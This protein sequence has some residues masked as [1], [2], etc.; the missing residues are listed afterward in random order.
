V[1]GW[2]ADFLPAVEEALERVGESRSLTAADLD[3]VKGA[4][5]DSFFT[6]D[7]MSQVLREDSL[8]VYASDLL[9]PA[10]VFTWLRSES[11]LARFLFDRGT[12]QAAK[13]ALRRRGYLQ[14][15][16]EG[17]IMPCLQ[18]LNGVVNDPQPWPA[19]M[20]AQVPIEPETANAGLVAGSG[21]WERRRYRRML[22][23]D[24]FEGA[25]APRLGY[26][27]RLG[28]LR[29][30]VENR[31]VGSRLRDE[32]DK[33]IRQRMRG[34]VAV[35]V[36]R[37]EYPL[38]NDDQIVSFP[39]FVRALAD[40]V[41]LAGRQWMEAIARVDTGV[42]E[43]CRMIR[44]GVG[45]IVL[46][47]SELVRCLNAAIADGQVIPAA[48]ATAA[49]GASAELRTFIA[50]APRV[51]RLVDRGLALF[52]RR[53]LE[54]AFR[55]WIPEP[56]PVRWD[57][58]TDGEED[59]LDGEVPHLLQDAYLRAVLDLVLVTRIPPDRM[60]RA[61]RTG[62][63]WYGAVDGKATP[64]VMDE[65]VRWFQVEHHEAVVAW[66]TLGDE[67][68]KDER[69]R[70]TQAKAVADGEKLLERVGDST[71]REVIGR[72]DGKAAKKTAGLGGTRLQE[73]LL[74][75]ARS[76][77]IGHMDEVL[78]DLRRV[79]GGRGAADACGVVEYARATVRLARAEARMVVHAG[80]RKAFETHRG[81]WVR[82]QADVGRYLGRDQSTIQ[83]ALRKKGPEGT[84]LGLAAGF[85]E[86]R[87]QGHTFE[88]EDA[89]PVGP[90][91]GA[92]G[93]AKK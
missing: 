45:G 10:N 49:A 21:M 69:D 12:A 40:P 81:R 93:K 43:K 60:G 92:P 70:E 44:D 5:M 84:L 24:L 72:L 68:G 57:E 31:L 88:N 61:T 75:V 11:P 62:L 28:T 13:D 9:H 47:E 20:L 74:E 39:G 26:S 2:H 53:T 82:S 80:E 8:A 25:L 56:P 42:A 52:N 90:G 51:Y 15:G 29:W 37:N 67:G 23:N 50:M 46:A 17:P 89:D 4:V 55:G 65:L 73:M 48:A 58:D 30:Y 83:R 36:R 63:S 59:E 7:S 3:I 18:L 76:V 78:K 79:N 64:G 38:L 71:L 27:P 77:E 35:E 34:G 1:A 87:L 6:D 91:R 32:L 19:E 22:L 85:A 16:V 66:E 86:L 14:R 41:S 33:Y 54:I